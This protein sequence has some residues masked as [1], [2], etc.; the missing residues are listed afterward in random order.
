MI[1]R[2]ISKARLIVLLTVLATGF[3]SLGLIKHSSASAETVDTAGPCTLAWQPIASTNRPRNIASLVYYPSNG[4]FYL[5]GGTTTGGA[6]PL[7]V[8]EY[9]PVANTWSDKALSITGNG[10]TLLGGLIYVLGEQ[11]LNERAFGQYNPV[12]DTFTPLTPMPAGGSSGQIVAHGS[13]I[14]AASNTSFGVRMLSYDPGTGTWTTPANSTNI[15][16]NAPLVS[17]ETL[18]YNYGGTLGPPPLLFTLRRYDPPTDMWSPAN[19]GPSM[20][21][22]RASHGG[23]WDGSRIWAVS[24]NGTG[25]RLPTTESWLPGSAAWISGPAVNFPAASFGIAYGNGIAVKAGGSTFTTAT[26]PIDSAERLD[27]LSGPTPTPT[28]TP[29]PSPTPTAAPSP[30]PTVAPSPTPTVAPSPTPTVAPSP[31]PTVI[32]SPT[33]T[34]APSPTPTVAPSPTPTVA[35]SPTPTVAPSPTPTPGGSRNIRVI[36]AAGNPGGTVTVPIVIDAFGNESS[37]SFSVVRANT[38][39]NAPDA[40][41]VLTNPVVT[42]GS[43]VPAGSNL[44]TNLNQAPGSVGILV[45]STN[46]YAAGTREIVRITYNIPA[47]APLGLYAIT[48]SSTP[49]V[50]SVSNAAGALLP[51][52]YVA[53]FVQV[54]AT[55]A[56]VEVSGR[57]LTPDG[58]GI[59]N[60]VVVMT[61][62]NG[63]LRYATTGSFGH[64]R[65]ED[66]EAGSAIIIGVQSKR[67][68]FAPRLM[69][70]T[71]SVD[72]IDFVALE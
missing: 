33:P 3:A 34:V 45:D 30:T 7:P 64:Y 46:T 66:V 20:Q 60:A 15:G 25:G 10:A 28:P 52:N 36:N 55:A 13:K 2:H 62:A 49:T 48:F 58:R 37:T 69:S 53:G 65:F 38:A 42:I 17:D 47:N 29:V 8:E 68:R 24:G 9:D 54:G 14:Y 63:T 16:G 67:F 26:V 19:Q 18:I 59:R 31:T 72:N 56:G 35:P 1:K 11:N 22:S 40:M 39:G 4:K 61:D 43:G 41:D 5:I 21:Q 50:Q 32:P 12:T 44:G 70:I 51:T 71:D 27:C 57:V 6:G 23:Y